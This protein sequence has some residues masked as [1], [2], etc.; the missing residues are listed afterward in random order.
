M[1]H[2]SRKPPSSLVWSQRHATTAITTVTSGHGAI[3][4]ILRASLSSAARLYAVEPWRKVDRTQAPPWHGKSDGK[5]GVHRTT[6]LSRLQDGAR[7][8][9]PMGTATIQEYKPPSRRRDGAHPFRSMSTVIVQEY[10]PPTT[11]LLSYLPSAAVPYAELSRLD[12]PAGSAYLFFPCAFGTLLAAPMTAPLVDPTQ[13]LSTVALFASG[14]LVMRGA[15]CTINDLWDRDFDPQ[16]AR[17]RLRPIARGAVKP[18]AALVYTG[19][20]LLAGLA[21]LVQFPTQC[22]WY[23]IPSLILVATYPLAKRI[24]YYPQVVLGTAFSW[25]TIMGFP[26]LG[27]DLLM[28]MPALIAAGCLYTSCVAWTVLYDMI[29]AHMDIKDDVKAGIKSIAL[30]HEASTKPV[31][32]GLAIVQ[33]SLLAAAGIATG[34]G[35]AFFVGGCGGALASLATMIWRVDLES[36]QSCWWWFRYGCWLTGGGISSGLLVD[37]MI[38][39][40]QKLETGSVRRALV[41]DSKTHEG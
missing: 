40:Q 11:G 4:S 6:F 8:S 22:L 10:K 12:K 9:R 32:T 16:V 30:A 36:V 15:G 19:A 26:A 35:P 37:Y 24:T 39:R 13:L 29:Y 23:G 34:A 17:T 5:L 31:L 14:A 21:I 28:D 38:Q 33:T 27:V 25:G 7:P 18:R 20:Q 41:E 2:V 1:Q 3:H